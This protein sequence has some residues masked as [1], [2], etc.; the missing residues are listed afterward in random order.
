MQAQGCSLF[1]WLPTCR[2]QPSPKLPIGMWRPWWW[3]A[4]PLTQAVLV[5]ARR[6]CRPSDLATMVI[7]CGIWSSICVED[8]GASSSVWCSFDVDKPSNTTREDGTGSLKRPGLK[9]FVLLSQPAL[10]VARQRAI[11]TMRVCNCWDSS[12]RVKTLGLNL[13]LYL[14][15]VAFSVSLL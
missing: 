14:A 6:C 5:V 12:S 15:M 7:S 3:S 9:Y 10:A 8:G 4:L 2:L 13:W 11:K 1:R